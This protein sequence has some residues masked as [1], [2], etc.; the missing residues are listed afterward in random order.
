MAFNCCKECELPFTGDKCPRCRSTNFTIHKDEDIQN[1][2]NDP[3]EH[4][5]FQHSR[6][7]HERHNRTSENKVGDGR[8]NRGSSD[9]R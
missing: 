3:G 7:E 5:F 8:R 6:L 4:N 9:R 2:E 1:N